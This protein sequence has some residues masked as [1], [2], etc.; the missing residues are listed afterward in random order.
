MQTQPGGCTQ[1]SAVRFVLPQGLPPRLVSALPSVPRGVERLQDPS[2]YRE[3]GT[4]VLFL[5]LREKSQQRVVI[6]LQFVSSMRHLSSEQTAYTWNQPHG[7]EWVP[8]AVGFAM[9]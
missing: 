1:P 5:V 3:C 2:G 7:C 4:D 6:S 8:E 9:N